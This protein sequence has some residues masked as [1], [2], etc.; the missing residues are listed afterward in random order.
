[1]SQSSGLKGKMIHGVLASALVVGAM[2]SVA[3]AA[4][5]AKQNITL[6]M[7]THD[8]EY[9]KFFSTEEK[10]WAKQYPQYNITFKAQVFP[11]GDFWNKELSTMVS[12]GQLPNLLDLEISHFSMFEKPGVLSNHVLDL[13][14]LLPNANQ[15][16]KLSPYTY[17]GRLYALESAL[18]PEGFYYQ[19]AI[20]KKYGIK[21]P[22]KTWNEFYQ[23]G[24]KLAKHGI[25]IA[26]LGQADA[27]A[28]FQT[29]FYED[30]GQY[31]D[32]SGKLTINSPKAITVLNYLKNGLDHGIFKEVSGTTFWSAP[33]YQYYETGKIAGVVGAD[34]Y[35]SA[36]LESSAAKMKGKWR[37]MP[38]PRWPGSSYTTATWGGT[39]IAVA[40]N[41]PHADL[42]W[43]LLK[44]AYG[45]KT[46]QVQRFQDI[47]YFPNMKAAM[48]D[49][50]VLN[51]KDPYFGGQQLGKTWLQ[52]SKKVPPFY[53]NALES[54]LLTD[55]GN[56]I[57]AIYAGKE[58][59]QQA[60]SQLSQQMNAAQSGY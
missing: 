3:I 16:A 49:P 48:A 54:E 56:G 41:T 53:Q 52:V 11:A 60:L 14:K 46:G 9:A 28:M 19:P 17:Q 42:A 24:L 43:S 59:A 57:T 27:N 33:M 51:V 35:A 8:Q 15:F 20:F 21:T 10:T 5:K 45:T 26:P 34:W 1:M 30:G 55:L 4:P 38:L 13:T 18:S 29:L 47:G 44:Y 50:K 37:V 12:G 6:T 7:W 58:S 40:K 39:G 2:S 32:A 22:I 23:D 25:A 36:E 31:F